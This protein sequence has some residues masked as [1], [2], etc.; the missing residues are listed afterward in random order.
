[1]SYIL[2]PEFVVLLLRAVTKGQLNGI[3]SFGAVLPD[4]SQPPTG[5]PRFPP[6]ASRISVNTG[7]E[8]TSCIK[9][10]SRDSGDEVRL[11]EK[12]KHEALVGWFAWV[13]G[14]G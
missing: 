1:M 10:S 12:K 8:P 3:A 14:G 4:R 5:R 11:R 9:K 6:L 7:T 2:L 13:G